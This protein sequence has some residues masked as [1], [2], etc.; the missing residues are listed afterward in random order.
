M[1]LVAEL[2]PLVERWADG[3]ATDAWLFAAPG[4]GPLNRGNWKRAV[5]WTDELEAVGRPRFR[6][7]DRRHTAASLWLAAGAD[8]KGVQ[9]ILG[10]ALPR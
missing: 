4:G 1:P 7:H 3:K 2:V 6:V 10:H 5:R 8:L 9:R